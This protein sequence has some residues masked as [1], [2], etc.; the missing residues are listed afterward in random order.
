MNQLYSPRNEHSTGWFQD[1]ETGRLNRSLELGRF[2]ALCFR[3]LLAA[4][5]AVSEWFS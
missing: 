2:L 5:W 4:I 1:I 3:N